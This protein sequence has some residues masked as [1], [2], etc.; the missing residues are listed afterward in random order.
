M[1]RASVITAGASDRR[2][3]SM[4]RN[5][6]PNT[7]AVAARRPQSVGVKAPEERPRDVVGTRSVAGAGTGAF[8]VP[9]MH[10]SHPGRRESDRY[11]R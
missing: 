7:T 6:V 2:P 4:N 9:A 1:R 8:S 5:E 10:R 3:T 11:G